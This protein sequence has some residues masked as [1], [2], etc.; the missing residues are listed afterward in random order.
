MATAE[1]GLAV[2]AYAPNEVKTTVK[3]GVPVS[4]VEDTEYPFRDENSPDAQ[5]RPHGGIPLQ[6]RIPAWATKASLTIN[7]KRS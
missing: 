4:I 2:V 5:S 3:G 7:G 6:L 1:N